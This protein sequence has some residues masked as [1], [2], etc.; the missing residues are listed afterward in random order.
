M[1]GFYLGELPELF[2]KKSLYVYVCFLIKTE[3]TSILCMAIDTLHT[4]SLIFLFF[5]PVVKGPEFQQ[6]TLKYFIG[7]KRGADI[8]DGRYQKPIYIKIKRE[9]F[10]KA[11]MGGGVLLET[12]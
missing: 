7:T 3:I 10:Y 4:F 11:M 6:E 9:I 8:S 5:F 12:R 2:K 1:F